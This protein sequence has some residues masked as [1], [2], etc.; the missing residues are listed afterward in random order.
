MSAILLTPALPFELNGPALSLA[1]DSI[2]RVSGVPVHAPRGVDVTIVDTRGRQGVHD[3]E[4]TYDGRT[5]AVEAKQVVDERLRQAAAEASK[6]GN[7]TDDR[8]PA[9]R[10]WR[11]I[12]G[13]DGSARCDCCLPCSS[14]WTASADQARGTHSTCVRLVPVCLASS[15]SS[16]F[17]PS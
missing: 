8:S 7:T 10:T 16:G 11:S 17:H 1:Y 12:T 5:V 13:H 14:S 4:S 2:H 3:L 9:H 15:Q 6:I